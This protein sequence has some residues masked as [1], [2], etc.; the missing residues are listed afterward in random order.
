[1]ED[2][3]G[4]KC[5]DIANARTANGCTNSYTCKT[6]SGTTKAATTS[7]TTITPTGTNSGI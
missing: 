2:I 7:T 3:W 1:L 6:V 4:L 5:A